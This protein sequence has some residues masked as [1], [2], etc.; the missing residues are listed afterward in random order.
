MLSDG[1]TNIEQA[2]TYNEANLLKQNGVI[3]YS[4]SIGI[5]V[6][7]YLMQSIA[8]EPYT[9]FSDSIQ[10]RDDVVTNA[11]SILDTVCQL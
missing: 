4:A 10:T 7:E 1:K 2:A 8:T 11:Q 3:L 5:S 6:D 9:Q